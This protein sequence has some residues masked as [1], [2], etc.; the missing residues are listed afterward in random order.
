MKK[1]SKKI[2]LIVALTLVLAMAV[3]AFAAQTNITGSYMAQG[4]QVIN[5]VVSG[6]STVKAFLNPKGYEADVYANEHDTGADAIG[7]LK[8]SGD[9]TTM[10][11]VGVNL[12]ASKVKVRA[13]VT[14]TLVGNFKFASSAPSPTTTSGL[15]FLEAKALGKGSEN[16][17]YALDYDASGDKWTD[18]ERYDAFDGNKVLEILNGWNDN[19][20][21]LKN[22]LTDKDAK[23]A[24]TRAFGA[25]KKTNKKAANYT[26]EN[27]VFD[28]EIVVLKKGIAE[29]KQQ[30]CTVPAGA[31]DDP[32][33]F[34]ARL[35][36]RLGNGGNPNKGKGWTANDGFGASIIWT[37]QTVD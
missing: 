34:I 30:L 21:W 6:G 18:S 16:A 35:S 19:G 11:I 27:M 32:S 2:A 29:S 36:G 28:D 22:D 31:T 9:I 14:S 1:Y 10:P 23:K 7:Q 24:F 15:V 13:A 20:A 17:S 8:P 4:T 26:K 25:L 12:G 3:P 5:V 37:F 33:Y